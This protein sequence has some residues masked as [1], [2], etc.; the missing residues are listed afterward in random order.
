MKKTN[1]DKDIDRNV[2]LHNKIASKYASRHAEI[3]NDFEQERLKNSLSSASKLVKRD[4]TKLLSADIG[5]GAG[6]LS[7]HLLDIGMN[8]DACDVSDKFLSIV[9]GKFKERGLNTILLNGKNLDVLSSNRYD[10][11]AT[12]SVLHH[13]PNYLHAIQE[14]ARICAV[15]GCVYIDHEHTDEYWNGDQSYEEFTKNISTIDWG[16]YLIIGN[17]IGKLKRIFNPKYST[18]GDIHVWPDDH[19]EW[20]RIDSIFLDAGMELVVSDDYLLF[21]G[22]YDKDIY[23]K[24]KD[25]CTDMRCRVYRKLG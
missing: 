6:N 15:G 4:A 11:V 16:K 24:Y 12:Y 2:R 1:S 13:I 10:F 14:M 25:V 19:I 20:N 23:N 7:T 9:S 8:V 18:E 21:K 5:C 22:G 3:Y 17:Y